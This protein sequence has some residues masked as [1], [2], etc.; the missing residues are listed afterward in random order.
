MQKFI[1]FIA[2]IFW[3]LI[4]SGQKY[5]WNKL[6]EY[7]EKNITAW[8][9]NPLEEIVVAS[10]YNLQLL[11][12]DFK[13]LFT[14]SDKSFGSITEVDARH[15]LKTLV[16]SA[17]QQML[18]IVDNTLSFQE[19]K[20]DLSDLEIDYASHVCDSDLSNRFWVYDELNSRLL[21]FEGVKAS[22]KQLEISNLAGMTQQ[23]EPTFI[24]ESLN[25]LILF[26]KGS[27]VFIFDFYGSLIRY[28]S[29]KLAL[30]VSSTEK[31]IYI[32]T[33][34]EIIRIER[35]EDNRIRI[36]LPYEG[37]QDFR[38]YGN[39]VYFM[40]KHGIKKYSLIHEP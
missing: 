35:G 6:L 4:A 10:K 1:L 40:D 29:N 2:L 13:L 7:N 25:Q 15:S 11:N 14:Q 22:Q 12:A 31:Y 16:F 28:H 3:S 38:I 30:Q 32:L 21:R 17:S 37:I 27:G 36:E 8:D 24:R 34:K 23:A 19:G 26:Y 9:I 39:N 5:S 18:G 33:D 20:I